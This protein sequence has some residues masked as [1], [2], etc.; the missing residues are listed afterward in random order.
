[1][2]GAL[3]LEPDTIRKWE[4]K[5]KDGFPLMS[6]LDVPGHS[7]FSGDNETIKKILYFISIF[8]ILLLSNSHV[9]IKYD[10]F[11]VIYLLYQHLYSGSLKEI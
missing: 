6:R 2:Y 1:M 11:A 9:F 10:Q 4:R 7:K 3:V 5:F 8:C